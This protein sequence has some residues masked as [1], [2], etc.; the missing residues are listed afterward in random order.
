MTDRFLV[1]GSS[2]LGGLVVC[3]LFLGSAVP[4]ALAWQG[5]PVA[6][7]PVPI[8]FP[9]DDGPHDSGIEWWYFTGHLFTE[10]GE[11]YGFEYVVFRARDGALEGFVSH[12]AVTDNP[13]GRFRYDQRLLG[14]QGVRGDAAP[15]DLDLNG[16]TRRGGDGVFSLAADMADYAIQLDVAATKPA[17]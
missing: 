16:W 9:R 8:A 13:R 7:A 17:G 1:L 12:F 11:R 2:W 4:V 14:A 10:G 15:L 3:L 6:D 5:T